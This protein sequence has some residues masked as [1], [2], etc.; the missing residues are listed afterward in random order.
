MN[1]RK[2]SA[3]TVCAMYALSI[4]A[5]FAYVLLGYASDCQTQAFVL[6]LPIFIQLLVAEAIGL[7]PLLAWLYERTHWTVLY[8]LNI[9]TSFCALYWIGWWIG[10]IN[11]A[12]LADKVPM[13]SPHARPTADETRQ[14]TSNPF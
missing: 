11:G 12:P 10:R 2:L 7:Q 13:P 1:E 4:V 3:L 5:C 8:A 14:E 6:E 9:S